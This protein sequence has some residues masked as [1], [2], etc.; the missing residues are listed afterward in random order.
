MTLSEHTNNPTL[1]LSARRRQRLKRTFALKAA[2]NTRD[3]LQFL[4]KS[5]FISLI[6]L[7]DLVPATCS[8]S[9]CSELK[10]DCD[11]GVCDYSFMEFRSPDSF[12][13]D[14]SFDVLDL[15]ANVCDVG[16][17][18][19]EISMTDFA[20]GSC[21][22]DIIDAS[23]DG[24]V[25]TFIQAPQVFGNIVLARNDSN[26]II[27]SADIQQQQQLDAHDDDYYDEDYDDVDDDNDYTCTE[28]KLV[29]RILVLALLSKN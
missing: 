9:N 26:L 2:Q 14:D 4:P 3:L 16:L 29:S 6:V 18:R 5:F 17:G 20:L 12:G 19:S 8:Q 7:D 27:V 1:S 22:R 13:L 11:E 10:N 25:A 21:F 15:P 24:V 28:L 23:C